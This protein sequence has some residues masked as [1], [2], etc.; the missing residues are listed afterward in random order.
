MVEHRPLTT[1]ATQSMATL[2][3]SHN[4]TLSSQA[5]TNTEGG[6]EVLSQEDI[7]PEYRKQ[8]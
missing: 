2:S 1:Q 5:I 4:T 3:V 8:F 6:L 7:H